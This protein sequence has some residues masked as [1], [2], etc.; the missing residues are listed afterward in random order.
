M[1]FKRQ[2]GFRYAFNPPIKGTFQL[3][4]QNDQLLTIKPG[5]ADILDLSPNGLRFSTE[6]DIPV[7]EAEWEAVMTFT[8]NEAPISLTGTIVWKKHAAAGFHYGIE[9]ENNNEIQEMIIRSIKQHIK[10][11]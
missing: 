8:L 6:L 2:E 4:K 9:C 1:R 10:S 7:N 11:S 5:A 3:V